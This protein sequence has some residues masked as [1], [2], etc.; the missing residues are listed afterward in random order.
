MPQGSALWPGLVID[1]GAPK[2]RRAISK[3]NRTSAS[4]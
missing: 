3:K 4:K 1:L 2:E